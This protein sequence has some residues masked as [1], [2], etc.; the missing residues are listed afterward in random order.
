MTDRATGIRALRMSRISKSFGA[1]R[2]LDRV[3]LT[4]NR[5]E[6]HAVIGENGAGKST[7][8]NVLSGAVAA[9]SGEIELF[10]K[11]FSPANPMDSRRAGVA[12]IYQELAL[13]PH[14][15][16]EENV[17]LGIE[18]GPGPLLHRA[19][20]RNRAAE[21]L[22]A[23]GL[24]IDLL[25]TPVRELP[26]GVQQLVE[27][28]RASASGFRILIMDEP[29]SSL[30]A[31][32]KDR[33]FRLIRGFKQQGRSV[34][35]I[36][37]FLDEVVEIADRCTILRDGCRVGTS[38]VAHSSL[39]ELAAGM[40]G[41]PLEKLYHR[42]AR[43]V[44][45][46]A[47]TV[48]D[49]RDREGLKSASFSLHRGE[50]LGIAGL[51]GSGRTDLLKAIFG[52]SEVRSGKVRIACWTGPASPFQRW[53][54][55]VGYVSE[56]RKEEGLALSLSVQDNVTLPRLS[57]LGPWGLVLPAR[58]S[59]ACSKWMDRLKVRYRS[60]RQPVRELSGGNQQKIALTRL[61]YHGC[62]VL[63]LDEPTRGIDIGSKVE[64]YRLIDRL[65][66]GDA[67]RGE[68]PRAILFAS[69]HLPELL[70]VCDRIAVMSRGALTRPAAVESLSEEKIM[71]LATTP[72]KGIGL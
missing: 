19:A 64:V 34:I 70:G 24:S 68:P 16:V 46:A 21:S 50:V 10:G 42:S 37:H 26:V 29:T 32:E 11:A 55:G 39:D 61:L 25:R 1:T 18:P 36:S 57:G 40:V 48:T 27:V 69:S 30:T 12:M 17:L 71:Q 54:Q 2:A 47:L 13:A 63:L 58:Q 31:A 6:V 67:S 45:E 7:L 65:A 66:V 22:R 5:G 38:Q 4:L 72:V 53:R 33:L 52:L 44:G 59:S 9:D 28:A 20:R 41:R 56:D 49:L 43:S 23:A 35:Y 8:M 14:L 62:D 60:T 3:D 15:T 51:V